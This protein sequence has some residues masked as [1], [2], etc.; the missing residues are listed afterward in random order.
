M[1]EL[2]TAIG[3]CQIEHAHVAFGREELL[4][5]VLDGVP[6]GLGWGVGEGVGRVEM[7]VNNKALKILEWI[8]NGGL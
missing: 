7:V 5:E 4:D 2:F 1:H 3:G 6:V 8:R